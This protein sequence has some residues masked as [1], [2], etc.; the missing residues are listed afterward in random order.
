V[1]SRILVPLDGS[2]YPEEILPYAEGIART[3]G[4]RLTLLRVV[5]D[6]GEM[7]DAREYIEALASDL[8]A[9]GEVSLAKTDVTSAILE[10]ASRDPPAFVAMST[11]GR[12]GLLEVLL[13]SVALGVVRN[14]GQPVL[15]YRPR[16]SPGEGVATAP[17][18]ERVVLPLDGS[19]FSESMIP[20]AVEMADSLKAHLV[21][22]H[23]VSPD[24]KVPP[25]IP[26]GDVLESSYVR[27]QAKGI[28]TTYGFRPDWDV[29]H[30]QPADAICRYAEGQRDTI[31]AM[32]SHSR[33]GLK[34][35][36]FG[37]VTSECL[38]RSGAPLLVLWP[39]CHGEASS[40]TW[41]SNAARAAS[42]R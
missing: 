10:E 13:G 8:D 36:I 35:T 33:S 22:V 11:H 42:S 41:E 2:A 17:K 16:G 1:R 15:I 38:R 18:I 28:E 23:V 26:A 6:E 29:L 12:T 34:R 25:G 19:A 20:A 40:R 30:G 5:G 27:S 32:S 21:L 31:L 39:E 4:A 24:V 14:S 3:T 7:R 37:S 9:E